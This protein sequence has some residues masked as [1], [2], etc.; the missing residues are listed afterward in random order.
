LELSE[1]DHVLVLIIVHTAT[2]A[3]ADELI[4]N[5]I[6]AAY[7]YCVR[8]LAP[9]L[10]PAMSFS[11]YIADDIG[12]GSRLTEAQLRYWGEVI[13]G[14]IPALP[15]HTSRNYAATAARGR[16]ISLSTTVAATRR[17]E[18][19]ASASRVSL[20]SV[21]C[22]V[23]FLAAWKEYGIEDVCALTTYTGR[24]SSR[25]KTLG[26]RTVRDFLIRAVVDDATSLPE[27]AR[28]VQAALMR[29]SISSRPPFTHA[30]AL[31][32]LSEQ[33]PPGPVT[34]TGGGAPAR[35]HLGITDA[36]R[37]KRSLQGFTPQLSVERVMPGPL[38]NDYFQ[39][40]AAGD[41]ANTA[42]DP[43][44][45]LLNVLLRRDLSPEPGEPI[46]FVGVFI[47]DALDENVVRKFLGRVCDIAEL[48][49][50]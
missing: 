30:R 1:Q 29:A 48:V 2:D 15:R 7:D 36:L 17:L 41:S 37:I 5:E 33:H 4:T 10:P 28:K 24:D 34:A 13:R 8:G 23:I 6:L 11:E 14:C 35:V 39:F 18:N 22:S 47:D 26:A 19:F 12:A 49:G 38:L 9:S 20:M 42:V 32:Q 16:I 31:A 25:L 50:T 3:Y 27:L 40:N 45:S 46:T 44:D 43:F 21:L